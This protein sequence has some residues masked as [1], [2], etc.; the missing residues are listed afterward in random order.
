MADLPL[1]KRGGRVA[2]K[3]AIAIYEYMLKNSTL[4]PAEELQEYG[5]P[6]QVGE[7]LTVFEG[8]I[9]ASAEAALG[10]RAS[11]VTHAMSTLKAMN[12]ITL[13]I[14]GNRIRKSIYLLNYQPTSEQYEEFK[15][16]SYAIE[17]KTIPNRWDSM[18]NDM[19]VIRQRLTDLERE[20]KELREHTHGGHNI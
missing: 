11:N 5:Y 6:A 2:E 10:I 16:R 17:R 15:G 1:A 9:Q 8:Y 13:L 12:A 4:R 19:V 18:V 14:T 3:N 20:V 7:T